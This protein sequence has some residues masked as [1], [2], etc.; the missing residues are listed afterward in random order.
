VLFVND[1]SLLPVVVAAA[2]ANT[3]MERFRAATGELLGLLG[4]SQNSI[5]LELAEMG[6]ARIERTNSRQVLGSMTDFAFLLEGY[7]EGGDALMSASLRL[8]EAPCG[9]IG[10][11]RPR[12]VA[13]ELLRKIPV[14]T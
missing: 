11:E 10:M 8:A 1:D 2:P 5:T 3:L 7:L 6:D 12:D 4:A 14:A 9:P 13:L